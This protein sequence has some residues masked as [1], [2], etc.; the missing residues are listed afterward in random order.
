MA[1]S[2]MYLQASVRVSRMIAAASLVPDHPL[3]SIAAAEIASVVLPCLNF[4]KCVSY[5]ILF[6]MYP[7]FASGVIKKYEDKNE[8]YYQGE[9]C[10]ICLFLAYQCLRSF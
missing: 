5:C 9:L 3:N 8:T 4:R 7:Y 2:N 1:Q 10:T 6:V